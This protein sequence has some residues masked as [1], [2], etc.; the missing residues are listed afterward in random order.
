MA[1]TGIVYQILLLFCYDAWWRLATC[2]FRY[3]THRCGYAQKQPSSTYAV[4][5]NNVVGSSK[6]C[7]SRIFDI[8]DISVSIPLEKLRFLKLIWGSNAKVGLSYAQSFHVWQHWQVLRRRVLG[9]ARRYAERSRC[10]W[11][12]SGQFQ[13][14]FIRWK[15][16]FSVV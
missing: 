11:K 5:R 8:I 3:A 15:R 2:N 12:R 4:G 6:C 16:L 13:K 7:W 14:C 1:E 9:S 10:A